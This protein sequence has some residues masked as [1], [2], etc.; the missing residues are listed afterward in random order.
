MAVLDRIGEKPLSGGRNQLEKFH[1]QTV[2]R[3]WSNVSEG[4]AFH[5]AD[6]LTGVAVFGAT[7]SGKTSGVAKHLALSYLANDFGGL[8]LCAKPEER[9]QWQEWAAET[10]RLDDLV[11][12]DG[13][14]EHKFNFMDWEARRSG[15]GGGLTLN[16][17]AL[18]DEIASAV[19]SGAGSA[20]GGGDSQFWQDSLH[21]LNLNLVDL[22]IFS[23]LPVTLS[24]L[25]DIVNTAPKSQKEATS[26]E[27]QQASICYAILSKADANT[28]D[29]DA[30]TRKDFEECR[31]YWLQDYPNLSEKTRS[32]IT[33]MFSMLVR[34]FITRPLRQLFSSDTNITPEDT[35]NGKIIIVDL[36]V[37]EYRLAGRV[38]NLAWKYCFQ[39]AVTRRIKP[40][41]EHLRPVFLWADEAQNFITRFDSEWHAVARS[42]G[43]CSV[44]LA[45]TREALRSVLGN[46]D[47]TDALLANLQCKFFCQNGSTDTN[48]WAAKLLGERYLDITSSSFSS[49]RDMKQSLNSSGGVNIS[50]DKRFFV[51][52]ARFTTLKR[53]GE[54]NNYQVEAI[55]YNGGYPFTDPTTGEQVPCS[56][57]TFDQRG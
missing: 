40:N 12:F 47:A 2:L 48:E 27:W 56:L 8:V 36:P 4:A 32:I 15:E 43:G 19:S 30:E 51:E 38:A 10:G 26:E 54:R 6:A 24:L 33:L 39:V 53:G 34:P 44:M 3:D 42:A 45:Q 21:H 22:P 35:F 5:I 11:I 23:G 37:Q 31:S 46:D 29:G 25:R 50:E 9:R 16:I 55:V 52:P 17:V 57:L 13:S 49:S 28:Q 14:G 7:G 18:L 20:E 1:P 41:N